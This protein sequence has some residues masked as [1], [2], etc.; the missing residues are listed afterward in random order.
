MSQLGQG[1]RSHDARARSGLRSSA[2]TMVQRHEWPSRATSGLM[3]RSKRVT[4]LRAL[5]D[6]LV[7]SREQR[8]RNLEAKR[9]GGLEVDHQL[10]FD[11]LLHRQFGRFLAHLESLTL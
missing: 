3:H 2:A 7:G 6:D 11:G 9:L 1:R 5:L 8:R 10:D 4:D